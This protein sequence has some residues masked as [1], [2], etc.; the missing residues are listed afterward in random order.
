MDALE[1]MT[2]RQGVAVHDFWK[3]YSRCGG[4]HARC[5]AHLLRDLTGLYEVTGESW[6]APL[7]DLLVDLH[8]AAIAARDSGPDRVAPD[9]YAS[10][11]ALYDTFVHHGRPRHPNPEPS[12]RRG[13][14]KRDW[15][16]NM[17][18][19]LETHRSEILAFFDDI[20]IPFDHNAAERALR[21]MKVNQKGS[22]TFRSEQGGHIFAAIRSDGVTARPHGQTPLAVLRDALA[23]HPWQPS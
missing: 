22:G 10:Y 7:M 18:T 14:V 3:P 1:V 20:T 5:N 11:H 2:G 16:Q 6:V 8:D 9:R 21:M 12:G 15:A 13:H 4:R 23:G 17:L 19:R